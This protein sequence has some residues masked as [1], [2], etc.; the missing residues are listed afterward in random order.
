MG[1]FS[2]IFSK[3]SEEAGKSAVKI[4]RQIMITL[5]AHTAFRFL[6]IKMLILRQCP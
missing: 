6:G 2:N 3:K 4:K 1:L 5:S